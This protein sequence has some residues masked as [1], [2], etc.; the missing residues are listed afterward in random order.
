MT[1]FKATHRLKVPH[2]HLTP[3]GRWELDGSGAS[4]TFSVMR[5]GANLWMEGENDSW[6]VLGR[7]EAAYTCLESPGSTGVYYNGSFVPE[8][9]LIPVTP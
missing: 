5:R 8:A 2:C 7:L 3:T 6:G 4:R 1:E 9:K